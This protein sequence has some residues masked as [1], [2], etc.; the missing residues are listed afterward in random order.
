VK[1]GMPPVIPFPAQRLMPRDHN[2]YSYNI[3]HLAEKAFLKLGLGY[4]YFHGI[5][6]IKNSYIKI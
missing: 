6:K 1:E 2:D 5:G 3:R 4:A